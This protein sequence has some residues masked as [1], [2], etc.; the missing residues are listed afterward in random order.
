VARL[1]VAGGERRS[2]G[3]GHRDLPAGASVGCS[4]T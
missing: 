1:C 4:L 2:A 3:T